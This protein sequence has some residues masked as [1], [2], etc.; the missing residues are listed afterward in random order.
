MSALIDMPPLPLAEIVGDLSRRLVEAE[1]DI[2]RIQKGHGQRL[3]GVEN[4]VAEMKADMRALL[5]RLNT[6]HGENKASAEQRE[7]NTLAAIRECKT[8]VESCRRDVR[9]N[10]S[11]WNWVRYALLTVGVGYAYAAAH[12]RGWMQ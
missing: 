7:L 6:M 3:T 4:A 1:D 11:V 5:E 8:E 2:R 12:I 9:E 10:N